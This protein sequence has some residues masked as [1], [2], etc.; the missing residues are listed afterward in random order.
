MREVI[1]TKL[2]IGNALD[3]RNVP[4][5]LGLGITAIVDLAIEEPPIQFPRDVVYCRFPLID[6]AGNQPAVLRAAIETVA[7]FV[8]LGTPTLVACGAGMSRSP[9]IVAAAMATTERITLAVALARL[10]AGQPHDVSPGLLAEISDLLGRIG[11][12]SAGEP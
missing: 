10:T 8:A 1:P 4:G 3:A 11:P 12:V 6:G 9:A 2:W 5:V 7:N